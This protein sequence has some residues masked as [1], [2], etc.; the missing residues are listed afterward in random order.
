MSQRPPRTSSLS[1]VDRLALTPLR[2]HYLKREL[3]TLEF[4]HE[5]AALNSPSS[6]SLLGPPFL[7]KARFLNGVPQPAP[8]PG[9][10]A[11]LQEAR[12]EEASADLP[13]LKFAFAH[14]VLSF[15]FLANCPPNFFSHKLQPFVYSLVSRNLSGE[16]DGE[17]VSARHRLAGKVEK[18]LGLILSAAVKVVENGGNEEVIRIGQGGQAVAGLPATKAG[19]SA[20]PGL[21]GRPSPTPSGTARDK[22]RE[23]SINVVAVRTIRVKGRVR[24]KDHEEFIVRTQRGGKEDIFVARRY[25]DFTRLAETLRKECVEQDVK[26]PPAKDK[27]VTN[28]PADGS[29]R[30]SIDEPRF[31]RSG[32]PVFDG[33]HVPSLARERNRL[34]LRAYLRSLLTNPVLAASPAFQSFLLESPIV[35]SP[36]EVRDV[37]VREEMDHMREAEAARFKAEVDGRVAE[38]EG[39]LRGFKEEMVK[40]DGLTRVFATIRQTPDIEGLPIEYRKVFEWARISLAST[41]YQ[42]FLGSDSSSST[43][44]QLKRIHGMMPYFMLRGVLK[45]SNPVAM[46]RAFLDLF[47]AR[48]FGSTSLVQRM[49]SQGLQDEAREL[50]EDSVLVARK[51]ADDRLC[52]KVDLYVAASK[53][54]QDTFKADAAADG[55]DLMAVILRSPAEPGLDPRTMQRVQRASMAYTEYMYERSQLSDP[56]DDEGPDNDDAWLFEDL[57]VY[58]RIVTRARDKEQLIEL[59]FEGAT[60]ELLKDIVTIFYEPLAKVYKAANIADSLYDLQVFVN[61][62]IKTVEAAEDESLVDP[63]KTVQL[64][65]SLVQRHEARFYHFVHQV[66]SKGEG[67]FDNLMQW[68]EL[69][70]NFVRDGLPSPVSLEVLLPHA[71]PQRAA[72]LAEVDAI[73]DYHRQLKLAHHVRMERRLKSRGGKPSDADA[74]AAFVSGVMEN[75]KIG[76]VMGDVEDI[77]IEDSASDADEDEDDGASTRTSSSDEEGGPEDPTGAGYRSGAVLQVIPNS[78]A[79]GK[80]GKGSKQAR[81]KVEPPVLKLIPKLVPLFVELVR[82]EL[83]EARKGAQLKSV[84]VAA[85]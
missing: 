30:G 64:F 45:I 46:I 82:G 32:S 11:A 62:L 22:E 85:A 69:F 79:K 28:A 74:D 19:S 17:D 24:S 54:V 48:P 66:H 3:V 58:M 18:H 35:L 59:I 14:F 47:L 63:Q 44:S 78:R 38:L 61:D 13:F 36:A 9:S 4:G 5:L 16:E 49:F 60:S 8:A 68:I 15:P 77:E 75:L 83:A 2:A 6:M 42:L 33:N 39:Y 29:P 84:S 40:S 10:A 20:S 23:F 57:Y 31:D 27:R 73:V 37:H 21:P 52:Q 56:E 43:F 1:P 72:V 70:V 25:G 50:R 80:G 7:P 65:I 81:Q 51:I 41:V 67:L 76:N 26:T 34:T 55:L 12:G 71:G 53:E